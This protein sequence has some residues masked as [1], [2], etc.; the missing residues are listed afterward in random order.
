MPIFSAIERTG[1]AQER[2]RN[3]SSNL[4]FAIEYAPCDLAN[5]IKPIERNHFFMRSNLKNR[6]GGSVDN[7][8]AG[9]DVFLAK[10]LDDFSSRSRNVAKNSRHAGFTNKA[11]QDRF[12]KPVGISRK[13]FFE[14]D[15]CHLPMARRRVFSI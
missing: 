4:V 13:G 2:P 12:W 8:L 15:A 5:L 14:N 3:D 11:I 6:V 1:L 7:R 9:F 10:L